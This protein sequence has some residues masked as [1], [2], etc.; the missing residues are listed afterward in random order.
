MTKILII[1]SR[2]IV[3]RIGVYLACSQ[4]RSDSYQAYVWSLGST[5]S[6]PLFVCCKLWPK[7]KSKAKL[8]INNIM[9]K[10]KMNFTG[11]K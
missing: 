1:R 7:S 2:E 9:S 6:D 5:T 3:Q 10:L 8:N 4:P 11:L